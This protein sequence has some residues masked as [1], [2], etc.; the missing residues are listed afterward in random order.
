LAFLSI[1]TKFGKVSRA[2]KSSL[3]TFISKIL[4]SLCK[5]M[6]KKYSLSQV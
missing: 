4:S 2:S 6:L 5:T 1:I 3:D